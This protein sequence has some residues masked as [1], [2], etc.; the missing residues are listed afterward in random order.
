MDLM[1]GVDNMDVIGRFVKTSRG[2][3]LFLRAVLGELRY[4]FYS[5]FVRLR[6]FFGLFF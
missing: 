5:V 2:C 6:F 3:R 1:D 4:A